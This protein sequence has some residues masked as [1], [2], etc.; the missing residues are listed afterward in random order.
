MLIFVKKLKK[1]PE[2]NLKCEFGKEIK[3][4]RPLMNVINILRATFAPIFLRQK[5]YKAKL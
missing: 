1:M 2:G 3:C 4:L 5:N